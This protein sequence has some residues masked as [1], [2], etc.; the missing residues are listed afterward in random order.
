MEWLI[1]CAIIISHSSLSSKILKVSKQLNP[2]SKK[3]F[4][5]LKELIGKNIEIE[6]DEYGEYNYNCKTKGTLKNYNETW[7]VIETTDKKNNKELY[8]Y[9]L[10][11][12]TSINLSE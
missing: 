8:Y 6:S 4:P 9:R 2:S 1:I 5:S 12:I 10:K 11:N 7:I 3:T